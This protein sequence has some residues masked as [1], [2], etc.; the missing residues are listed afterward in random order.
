MRPT[1][2]RLSDNVERHREALH[3]RRASGPRRHI[4]SQLPLFRPQAPVDVALGAQVMS[5]H[6]RG[7]RV[8]GGGGGSSGGSTEFQVYVNGA[9]NNQVYMC[10]VW[11]SVFCSV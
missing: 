11:A 9:C 7:D 6:L 10:Q 3:H 1:P 8:G 2:P 5:D 4:S